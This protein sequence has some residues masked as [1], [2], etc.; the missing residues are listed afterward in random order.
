MSD[1]FISYARSTEAVAKAAG[2]ALTQAGF[3]IWRDDELP[4]HRTYSEVIEERLQA[5]KAVLVLWS[6]EALRSQWVRA[7]ADVAREAGTLVQMSVDG[8]SP[9]IPFNQIQCADI[10]DW[11]GEADHPGWSK[12][13]DSISS[14]TGPVDTAPKSAPVKKPKDMAMR[15]LVLPFENMSNDKDQEYF[16]DGISEDI[17]TDLSA[18]SSLDVVARNKAFSFKGRS[19][20]VEQLANDLDVTHVVEGSV[21]KGPG[22]VRI[23]AQLTD[24]ISLSQL[25]A[26]RFDREL[27]DIF[28]IQDEISKAIVAALR[29][30]LE[31]TEKK[32]IESRGTSS[33]EAYNLYL[34]ARQHWINGTGLDRRAVEI[35]SRICRQ[36][37][38]VDPDYAKAWGLLSLA[39]AR[40]QVTYD[41][42]GDVDAATEKALALDPDNVEALC[43]KAMM[44]GAVSNHAEAAPLFKRALEIDPNSFEVN[45]EVARGAY[46]ERKFE[47]A[48]QHYE[49][50]MSLL[51]NDFHSAGMLGSCY[52]A[53]GDTENAKRAAR[54]VV[55]RVEKILEKDPANGP[56]YGMGV[57]A[58]AE[59]GNEARANDWID[60]A[61]MVDPDNIHMRYN[62]A[63]ALTTMLDNK[64]KALDV[65]QPFFENIGYEML[66]HCEADPDLDA[67]RDDPRF[68]DMLDAARQRTG[69]AA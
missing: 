6:A 28:A 47:M 23:T 3:S 30:K 13:V 58:L 40:L 21:R 69:M 4:A 59:L 35:A 42:D 62:L 67:L 38:A 44:L 36:A 66:H 68:K 11:Q 56:A 46:Q 14:L 37:I 29:L 57:F 53:I 65:L 24:A 34:M 1:I 60:R 9:P 31:P 27:D 51:E 17:I 8:T 63:C 5:A 20:A 15:V 49:K 2:E 45:K 19:V 50:A 25:W 32:A 16:S 54:I 39:L 61:L 12:I 48:I 7:E 55:A 18:I 22:R 33:S 26:D 64:E 43:A 52:K 41:I 10:A